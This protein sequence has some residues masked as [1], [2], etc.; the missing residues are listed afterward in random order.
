MMLPTPGIT[1]KGTPAWYS[2]IVRKTNSHVEEGSW[3]FGSEAWEA[4]I[5]PLNYTRASNDT[6]EGFPATPGIVKRNCS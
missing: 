4:C 2:R 1:P 5:L 6:T 3:I